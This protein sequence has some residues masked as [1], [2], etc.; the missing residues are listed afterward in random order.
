MKTACVSCGKS[1]GKRVCRRRHNNIVCPVCCAAMRDQECADCHFQMAAQKFPALQKQAPKEKP[2]IMEL[3]EK[4]SAMADY[5]MELMEKGDLAQGKSILHNLMQTHPRYYLVQFAMGVYHAHRGEMDIAVPYFQEA[6]NIFPYFTEAYFNLGV[7]YRNKSDIPNMIKAFRKVL[8]LEDPQSST[9]Q[10]AKRTLTCMESKILES[11]GL[12][13]DLFLIAGE[14]FQQGFRCME[15][16]DWEQATRLFQKV[17][18]INP[19]NH[20]AHGNLGLCWA[21]LGQKARALEALD[22]AIEIYPNYE[23][24][25]VNRIMIK[26]LKEGEKPPSEKL[27]FI[28]Y[29]HDYPMKNKSYIQTFLQKFGRS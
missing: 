6:V 28:G 23:L 15:N 5:A 29:Y 11:E 17:L 8:E 21:Y 14:H 18:E 22:K 4:V 13:M 20:Q 25:I 7:A 26:K 12:T 27:E 1:K 3:N 24:A 9:A 2:F 19:N 16:L 10:E